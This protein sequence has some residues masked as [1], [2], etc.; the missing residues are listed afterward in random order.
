MLTKKYNTTEPIAD[1]KK[2][3]EDTEL[4]ITEEGIYIVEAKIN[5]QIYYPLVRYVWDKR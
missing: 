5:N 1:E 3:K 2:G 4:I